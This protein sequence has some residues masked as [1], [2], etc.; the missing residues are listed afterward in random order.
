MQLPPVIAA[1]I[2]VG[3][4]VIASSARAARA[5]RRLHGEAQRRQGREAWQ[6][7]DI[8]DWDSWL[9]GLWQKRLRS[10]GEK[11]L[12]LTTLQ[13]QQ[14]WVRQ[15]KPSIEGRRLISVQG[16]AELAQQAYGLL[17][18]YRALDFLRGEKAGGPDV[19]DFRGWARGFERICG[20]EGWL[21]RTKLPLVFQDAVLAGEVEATARLVLTGFDRV[22]PAQQS[23]IDAFRERGHTVEM[24]EAGE[25]SPAEKV[26]LVEAAGQRDEI[27][28]SALWVQRVLAAAAAQG[29]TPRIAVVVPNVS[30]VRPEIE[31]IFRHI[32]APEAVAIGSGEPA[33]P[34]EFSLGVPLGDVPMARSALLLLRW[35][36]EA[37]P[38]DQISWLLLSGFVCEHHDE[39]LPGAELDARLRRQP[40]RQPEQDLETF[41]QFLSEGW[42][43]AKP[44][45]GLRHRLRAS[46][47]LLPQNKSLNFAEWAGVAE[48]VLEAV[49]WP[50]A[51]QL[52]S[53]DFQVQARWSQ[54]LDRVAA[55]AFAGRKVDYAEFLAVLAHQAGQTIFA[56]ESRDA[57]VQV[58]GPLEAAGLSFDALWFLGA[59]D[60]NWPAVARPHP[61]LTRSLQRKHGMPHADITA[62]WKLA[63]QVTTRLQSSAAQCIFSYTSQNAEGA[64]RP[65][66]L[67]RSGTQRLKAIELR[68]SIGAEEYVPVEDPFPGLTIE[69]EPAAIVP[70]PIEQ[71][72]GG[73]EILRRQAA[74]PFQSFATRRLA[75]RA[76]DATDWG[77]EARERGSVVHNILEDLWTEL[78]DRT[79]LRRARADALLH[80]IVER[81]V[82]SALQKFRG[83]AQKDKWSHAYL[84]A[85]QERIVSLIE[86]WLDYEA[87][88]ADFTVEAGEEKLTA[89]VGEL[90]LQV[91]VD[92]ID[93]VDGGRVIID[94]K[95]G[96]LSAIS[97][98][99]P[100]PDEPQLPL[101]AGFGRI[102]HLKGVLLG[103]V[104]EDKVKFIGRVED[105]ALVMPGDTKLTKPAYSADMLR[106]W[107]HALLDLGQQFLNGEAQVDP[108]QYPKTCEFCDLSGL[109]RIAENDPT[110]SGDEADESDD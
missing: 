76:M 58:L 11:R 81:H 106:N 62:D 34:F 103:R 23:L 73:A 4:T 45:E 49:H 74:C 65:S 21:S 66:T 60:A 87:Q 70:W 50:G 15:V 39:L 61:F 55:L 42:R 25:V 19:E 110:A 54:L 93:V 59:D 67:V 84:D 36:N 27:A 98:D 100:R 108:K 78:K 91:R 20:K 56:P 40:M 31:R 109:C 85:E 105:A 77:L 35:I 96:L 12:L 71:D 69:E 29:Q 75:A 90:K 3:D 30:N 101:Y 104:R 37:M 2:E 57:A 8:L 48:Q 9:N 52:Q 6:S 53:E 102:D 46:R 33:L 5:L 1:A 95:T 94:Y 68:A 63:Q 47:R 14:L 92:R 17:C 88:R 89:N 7:A 107:Q 18:A 64:R 97:W 38:Q 44:L 83:R 51:H 32:L 41:L 82:A 13:E 72:A 86:E 10:G 26:F 22:T 24:A 43:E 80:A 16:V 79:G 28:T 99:G